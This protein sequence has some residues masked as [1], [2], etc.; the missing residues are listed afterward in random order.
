MFKLVVLKTRIYFEVWQNKEVFVK[1]RIILRFSFFLVMTIGLVLDSDIDFPG[2][3]QTFVK[4]LYN[5]IVQRGGTAIILT[6]GVIGKSEEAGFKIK[7]LGSA[8]TLP[9]NGTE[10]SFFADWIDKD[11]IRSLIREEKISLLHIQGL[12]GL[13]GMRFLDVKMV[14]SLASFHNF[15]E[16]DKFPTVLKLF[17]PLLKYYIDKLDYRVASSLTARKLAQEIAPGNYEVIPPGVDVNF[18]ARGEKKRA[19][20]ADWIEILFV[21]RLDERKG[22]FYLLKAYSLLEKKDLPVALTVIGRGPQQEG[23]QSFVKKNNLQRV[24]FLGFVPDDTLAAHYRGADIYCSPATRGECFGI[25]LIEAM[26]ARLPIVAFH[27]PGYINVLRGL[28]RKFLIP[29]RNYQALAQALE[30]L[31]RRPRWRERLSEWSW[32]EVQQYDW[33]QVGER[34][35]RIYESL[36]K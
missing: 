27:N 5:Y 13:L 21:G 10:V 11:Y 4:G 26:A 8:K 25:V 17:F 12:F 36:I 15:V 2:G 32:R 9:G 18:F 1:V 30:F 22:L 20:P 19:W 29:N 33:Q 35:W 31:V 3:V 28:G 6:S 16:A 23:A 24:K 34:Y 14:P 7:R